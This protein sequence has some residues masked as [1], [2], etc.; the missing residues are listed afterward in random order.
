MPK[1]FNKRVKEFRLA[2]LWTQKQMAIAMEVSVGTIMNIERGN[3]VS[4]LTR[5]K[6]EKYINLETV[7]V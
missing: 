2:R 1:S 5:A 7:E 4:D 6:V 3:S